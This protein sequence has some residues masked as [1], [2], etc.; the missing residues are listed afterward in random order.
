MKN[1]YATYRRFTPFILA[2]YILAVVAGFVFFNMRLTVEWVAAILFVA[3]LLSGRGLLFVRDWGVFI[4]V[5][6]A[7]QLSS[8]IATR[9]AFPWHLTELIDADKF[10][11]LGHVPP[12]W[13]QQHLYHPGKLEPWDVVS[14]IV[15][16]LHF[17]TPLV[18]GFL[19]WMAN[20]EMFQKFAITFV[21]V[22]VAGFITYIVYPSV[23]PW[24]A[25]EPLVHV[26]G[27]YVAQWIY[28]HNQ[29]VLDYHA[30]GSHVYLPGVV[31]V[32]SKSI[33]NWFNPYHGNISLRFLHMSYD[34]VGAIPSEHAAFPMLF[35]LF[36]RRQFGRIGYLALIYVAIVLFSITYLGQHYVID[37]VIGFAYVIAGYAL[38]MHAVPAVRQ[39]LR[40]R[41]EP[42]ILRP[43]RRELIDLEEA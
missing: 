11:F 18:A 4:L 14:Y 20:R 30:R 2:V 39:R 37:A 7:W 19:L 43:R 35:F 24:M 13:L 31:N 26:H 41:P 36:L 27:T 25:A 32:F 15:Y 1:F 29:W 22:T 40:E 5:L 23:P 17:L 38:V 3:A 8:P 21:V 33:G 9:F 6:V 10:M 34:N 28:I 42:V 12:Q 16:M